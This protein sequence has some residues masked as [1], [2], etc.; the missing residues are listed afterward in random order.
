MAIGEKFIF[1]GMRPKVLFTTRWYPNRLNSLDGNFIENHARAIHRF[2]DIIVLYVGAD[3]T[4]SSKMF[5]LCTSSPFG[6]KVIHVYY[7]NNDVGKNF[8]ARV[9]KFFRYLKATRIGWAEVKRNFGMPD[10]CH[11]NILTR[12]ALLPI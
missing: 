10:V 5:D 8:F 6:F 9:I 2:A 3:K 11:V 7:R 1:A 12:A 4:M